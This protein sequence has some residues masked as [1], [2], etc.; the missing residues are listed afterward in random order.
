M[1]RNKPPR[2]RTAAAWVR[3]GGRARVLRG[4][5]VTA[6]RYP[7][8]NRR[9]PPGPGHEAGLVPGRHR[10]HGLGQG[11]DRILWPPQGHRVRTTRYQG[12]HFGMRM[13]S[14]HIKS[15]EQRDRL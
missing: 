11:T 8:G 10:H 6:D 12:L 9:L 1:S 13:G 7:G 15:P 14:M 4:A 5:A 3:P 2:P